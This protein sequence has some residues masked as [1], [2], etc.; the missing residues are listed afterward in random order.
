MVQPQTRAD[1][2]KRV[3]PEP[4]PIMGIP[5]TDIAV[6]GKN[7][8]KS[9]LL[10][11]KAG[12]G[13][14]TPDYYEALGWEVERWPTFD[15]IAPG[16]QLQAAKEN[17]LHFEG[18]RLGRPG[19]PMERMECLLM[20]IDTAQWNAFRAAQQAKLDPIEQQISDPA[21]ALGAARGGIRDMGARAKGF[22]AHLWDG[23]STEG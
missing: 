11:A 19:E 21:T 23:A 9:Y 5:T 15:G 13:Y 6:R 8:N 3:D 2:A 1:V 10:V 20:S 4:R 12:V 18:A 22:G 7:P 14:I 16:P 17:S